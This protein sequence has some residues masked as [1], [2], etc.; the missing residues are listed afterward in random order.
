[1]P[2]TT[3]M[4]LLSYGRVLL[5]GMTITHETVDMTNNVSV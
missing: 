5:S 2:D 3:E 4:D 1:M